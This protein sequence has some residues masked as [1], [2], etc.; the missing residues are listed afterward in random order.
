MCA[1]VKKVTRHSV[2]PRLRKCFICN[3][4]FEHGD[5]RIMHVRSGIA[6]CERHFEGTDPPPT[7][8]DA[9]PW[10]G[11]DAIR[12][13]SASSAEVPASPP[14]ETPEKPVGVTEHRRADEGK[15]HIAKLC[16]LQNWR[17]AYACEAD[18]DPIKPRYRGGKLLPGE[19]IGTID[20]GN[21]VVHLACLKAGVVPTEGNP[22]A[23]EFENGGNVAAPKS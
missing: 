5:H 21:G 22:W 15:T 8:T 9:A 13:T 2:V 23:A 16:E 7:A 17:C 3:I 20:D 14:S 12:R 11:W 18:R 1:M 19:D 6:I 10:P 4:E